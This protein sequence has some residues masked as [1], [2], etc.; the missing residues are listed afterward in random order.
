MVLK[1]VKDGTQLIRT[2]GAIYVYGL[3]LERSMVLT[4]GY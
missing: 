3:K 1:K 4:F 2:P